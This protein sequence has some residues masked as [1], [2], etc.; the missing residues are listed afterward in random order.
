MFVREIVNII[1]VNCRRK[2][3]PIM[4]IT[5]LWIEEGCTS[6]GVCEDFCP[7]VFLVYVGAV[8][9]EDA[10]FGEYEESIID[11]IDTCPAEAIKYED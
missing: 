5:K 6:C 10:D 8:V 1:F 11:A 7:N 4:A 2:K 9:K 3:R